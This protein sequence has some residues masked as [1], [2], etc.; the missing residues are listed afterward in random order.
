MGKDVSLKTIG[1]IGHAGATYKAVEYEGSTIRNMIMDERMSITNMAVEMGAK[2][3]LMP[4]DK[5]TQIYLEEK[6]ITEY[7]VDISDPDAVFCERYDFKAEEL[8][9]QVACPHGVD[10]VADA[11]DVT[12]VPIHQAYLGSCT[13]GRLNDIRMAARLLKGKKIAKGLRM[14]VSPASVP[15][16][17]AADEAGYL[18]TLSDAGAVILAPTCGVCVG[19]HSGMIAA[20]ETCISS[21]NRNF[22]GRMGSKEGKIYLGSPLTVAA[23]ALTGK[24]T[25]PRQ[26]L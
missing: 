24:I 25:D 15:I 9:P 8:V 1:T 14:L 22:I 6:G 10:N 19:L 5:M 11:A 16:W 2:V 17:N 23:S 7:P 18:R 13:G 26:V 3:G 4:V 20:G 21:S 12:D